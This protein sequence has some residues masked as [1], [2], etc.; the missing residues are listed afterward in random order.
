VAFIRKRF[1]SNHRHHG[2]IYSCQVVETYREGGKVKQRVVFNLGCNETI[3]EA[4]E[5]RKRWLE[6]YRKSLKRGQPDLGWPQR[7]GR[8]S[9]SKEELQQRAIE[10]RETLGGQ[11]A[12][13]EK[14]I[15]FLE[16]VLSKNDNLW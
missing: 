9:F 14:E 7:E 5:W 16:D 11:I 6:D 1:S 4:L 12:K 8:H 3:A 10:W 2:K 15:A 13:W